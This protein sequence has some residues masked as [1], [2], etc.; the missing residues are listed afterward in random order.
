MDI[1]VYQAKTHL[2]ELLAKVVNGEPVTITRHGRAIARLVAA[3]PVRLQD[4]RG[5]IE[6]MKALAKGRSADLPIRE[7]IA[8]GRR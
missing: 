7:M 5:V 1:G 4:V 3:E 2:P 8:E 6:E